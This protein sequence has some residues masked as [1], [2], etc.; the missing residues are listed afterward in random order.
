MQKIFITGANGWL[1]INLIN[2]ILAKES[3]F[4]I[5]A[6]NIHAF[7]FTNENLDILNKL[8]VNICKGDVQ[9]LGLIKKFLKN[10]G[11]ELVVHLAGIIHPSL[12]T[13][14]FFDINY[15]GTKNIIEISQKIGAK[16]I[17]LISSNSAIG[18]NKSNNDKDIFTEKSDF[19]P[20]MKYGES[21]FLTE[22]FAQDFISHNQAPKITII[23]APWFYGP[24]QP[25]RQTLFFSM[26]K[27]GKFPIVGNGEN[28]RSMVYTENL[29]QTI[30]L[31]ALNKKS[32]GETYWI[33]DEKPYTMNEI[34]TT[35]KN[36]MQNEFGIKCK[37]TTIKIPSLISD[38]A[39][40]ADKTL[41]TFGFYHQKIHVLSEMNKN[42]FCSIK[43]AEND[44]QYKPKFNLYSGMT[45][46]IK[47][48]LANNI[49]I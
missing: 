38:C 20:Y 29:S 18:C 8:G 14:D 28:K 42:I 31:A 15:L 40:L 26:I 27:D 3:F 24:Y 36:V 22:K 6:K 7:C 19:N 1:G 41:Q 39:Y 35:T 5:K 13:S 45:E 48:C 12:K 32:D 37:N 30:M 44:L 9:D 46:S 11:G 23:R 10:S 47:W 16:K 49:K 33:A 43:K 25:K 21:K 2:Y 4:H 17:I 34:I